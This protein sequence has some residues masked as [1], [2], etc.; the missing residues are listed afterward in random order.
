[1][2]GLARGEIQSVSV[3]CFI[4]ATEDEERVKRTIE[5]YL[6]IEQEPS[7]EPLEGHFGNRI[8]NVAWHLTGDAAW[9]CLLSTL[10]T[11]GKDERARLGAELGALVDEHGALY[12]RLDKQKLVGGSGVLTAADPV[13]IRVKPRGFMMGAEPHAFYRRLLELNDR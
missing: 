7:E 11:L 10:K 4:Q 13:R 5:R 3:S 9:K 1:M 8:V 6:G 2:R 12:L